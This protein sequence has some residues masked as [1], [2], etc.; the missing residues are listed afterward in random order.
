MRK[1]SSPV[2][3]GNFF[4]SPEERKDLLKHE[5]N[6]EKFIRKFYG[7]A[8]YIHNKERW[9]LWLLDAAPKELQN[10]PLVMDRVNK[11][12]NYRL[13]SKKGATR[14]Y[15]DYPT[16]FME[17]RQPQTEYIL[18]PRHSSEN[19]EY[20]PMGYVPADVIC[21]DANSLI[22]LASLYHFGVLTSCVHMAWV[23]TVCGRI[24]SDYRYSNT[25]V[26]NNFPWCNP[27]KE[28]KA[29]IEQTAQAIL[30]ARQKYADSSLADM[31]G[32][33]MYLYT[34][35]L[36]AHKANDKAVMQAY[37][38]KGNMAEMDMV[39]KLLQMYEKLARR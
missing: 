20:I 28:Q 36:E 13:D 26:Y 5:P 21:G 33:N 24:K 22:P 18:V 7:A 17:N 8:E 16:K 12:R 35:L 27:T 3:D 37:G 39:T 25:I 30:D 2:D 38:F 9:C 4:L 34:D 23:R 15:A 32:E 10:M 19:R 11:V 6:A 14:Q 29:K 31:Y 1:G